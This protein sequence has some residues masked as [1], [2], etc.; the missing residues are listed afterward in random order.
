MQAIRS[1]RTITPLT[2]FAWLLILVFI[3]APL[4]VV[5][6]IAFSTNAFAVFPPVGFSLQWFVSIF[7]NPDFID[8]LE[9]SL[10]LACVATLAACCLGIP[11]AFAIT[12]GRMPFRSVIES[13]LLSPL[14]VPVL[15]LG[16]ALLQF[17]SMIDSEDAR[18]NLAIGHV[19]LTLPYVVRSV[20]VSL[21][22]VDRSLEEA[23]CV[24]GASPRKVFFRATLPQISSGIA[25]GALFAFMMSFDD[26]PVAMWLADA[27][28]TPLPI[29][30]NASI[31][32]VFDPSIAAMST[33]MVVIGTG[34]VLCLEKLVG[35]R[36]AMGV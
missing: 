12:R 8:A 22:Q 2:W 9:V 13:A 26:F 34:V 21:Q 27:S 6:P 17:V 32:R 16:L 23:A 24:L 25:A 20:M 4:A 35:L 15:I 10:V 30:L 7:E 3:V 1:S 36:R 29:F 5:M 31:T 11:A 14:V 33:V 18:I 28:T 19:L